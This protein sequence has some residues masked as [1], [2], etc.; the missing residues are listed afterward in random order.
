M[1]K[2]GDVCKINPKATPISDDTEVSFVPMQ[3]VTED[4][5]ID[6]SQIRKYCDVKK[7][8]TNFQENDI[9]FAKITP[10]ME[11]GK[12]AIA[13]GLKNGIGAGSTEFHIMRPNTEKITSEWLYYLTSWPVF[14]RECEKNMTGSAGQK[15]VPKSFLE[16]YNI[17][18]PTLGEQ[19]RIA[20]VLDKISDLIAKRREQLDK[21]DELVKARFVEIMQSVPLSETLTIEEITE[22]VK[23]GFVGTCEKY[24]TDTDG[25]PML[26]TGNITDHGVTLTD[27]KYVT[28]EFH[29]K[30]KKSQI[31]SGDLLIARHGS[32]G[33]ANVYKG[34]EAQ[35]LNAVVIVPNQEI[36]KSEFL[37]ALINS[38]IVKQQIEKTLVGSTQRVVNTK[39]I[40]NLIVQIPS[41]PI[42]NL[43]EDFVLQTDKSKLTIQQSLDKLEVLKKALMQQYFG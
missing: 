40:A 3:N 30:N 42:Q 23:V 31:K 25:V 6:T 9:L 16:S 19:C 1:A 29:K 15:R 12:G 26:R 8:F 20:A 14:R 34:P 10:C 18:I 13:C 39:S 11:N 17:K 7:G 24:Y 36:V 28:R 21:L 43:Y 41:L 38:D 4:G 35:C 5:G 2:L 33:Q 32:N 37:A 27:L 22:R